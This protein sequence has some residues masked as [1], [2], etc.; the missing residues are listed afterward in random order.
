MLHLHVFSYEAVKFCIFHFL[1]NILLLQHHEHLYSY[2]AQRKSPYDLQQFD[3]V[4]QQS[5]HFH[6]VLVLLALCG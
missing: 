3:T 2:L 5:F 4:V 1:F 6:F